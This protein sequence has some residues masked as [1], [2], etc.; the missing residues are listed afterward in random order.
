[1]AQAENDIITRYE[2]MDG[3]PIKSKEYKFMFR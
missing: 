1:M 2:I 3:A